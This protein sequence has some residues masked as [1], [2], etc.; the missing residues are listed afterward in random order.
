MIAK[1][2]SWPKPFV[3][4]EM[5]SSLALVNPKLGRR[6]RFMRFAGTR[7]ADLERPQSRRLRS[8]KNRLMA[9]GRPRRVLA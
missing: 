3:T 4:A 6:Q 9:G 2:A 7:A 1:F 5:P 8:A